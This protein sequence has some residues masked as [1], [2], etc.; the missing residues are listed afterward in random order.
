MHSL[1]SYDLRLVALSIVVAALASFTALDLAGRI[2][3]ARNWSRYA[4]LA[5]AALAMGGGI[6]S[7]HFIGM[8]AFSMPGMM[9]SY[10]FGLTLLSLALP[11]AVTAFGFV[12]AIQPDTRWV[13]LLLSGIFMGS[14]IAGMHYTGMAAMRMNA[15]LSYEWW[16]VGISVA[17]AIGAATVALWL[18]LQRTSP[19]QRVWAAIVMGLAVSGMHYTA[20]RGAVFTGIHPMAG[21][22]GDAS[23][24]PIALWIAAITVVILVLGLV[25]AM[26]DRHVISLTMRESRVM[27]QIFETSHLYKTLTTP[28]G[29]VTYAN[30]TA[31]EGIRARLEDVTGRPIWETPW[32]TA[33]ATMPETIKA[34]VARVAAG[35]PEHFAIKLNLPIG[36]RAFEFSMRPVTDESGKVVA[37]VPEAMDITARLKAE[38]SL[39]Q[40]Q[41][42]EAIGNL[43]GGIAHD[44]NNLLMAV[45]GSLELMRKRLPDDPRL[46]KLLD[47]AVEGATRGAALTQRMLSFAR[48]QDLRPA[49]VDLPVLVRGMSELLSHAIGPTI[50]VETH[51]PLELARVMA[52]KSQLELAILNLCIN[53]RDA[54]PQG[55]TITIGARE[56]QGRAEEGLTQDHYVCLWVSDTGTG[57]DEET[58]KRAGEPFFTT[59]GLGRG[60][61]LGLSMVYGLAAQLQGT[62]L[63]KS[64]PGTGT[65]VEIWLPATQATAVEAEAEAMLPSAASGALEVL[66]VDD[67][68]LVLDN[69]AAML[70]DLGHKVTTARSAQEAIILLRREGKLDLLITDHAMPEMTGLQLAERAAKMRPGLR[71]IL[72]TGYAEL[73][74]GQHTD[75]PRLGKPFDQGGLARTIAAAMQRGELVTFRP[76]SA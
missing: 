19:L 29:I 57:M 65:T 74:A 70:E 11:I 21:M 56:E 37:L 9:V 35:R 69:V 22:T 48:R 34:A 30:A 61:G 40:A 12:V 59:K 54:M 38:Q 2:R 7:M 66:A 27:R 14:G 52:D 46:L 4:W 51:F 58:L 32:F 3:A 6:W 33:T 18:A 67:D 60:T 36:E 63:L 13:G 73:P 1:G 45:S 39:H 10:D 16:W 26:Y 44:F 24:V 41:K 31:L 15:Q 25:A 23:Q 72:A 55:G 47:N 53:A 71:I 62:L 68:P 42:M 50:R 49:P 75:L 5:A 17:I 43:T 20:M 8:L 76:K 28:D 64:W